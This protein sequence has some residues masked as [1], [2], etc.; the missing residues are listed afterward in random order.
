ML[1]DTASWTS[2]LLFSWLN[3]LFKMG[4]VRQLRSDDLPGLARKDHTVVWADRSVGAH[5]V[6]QAGRE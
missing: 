4:V 3:P 5:C 1:L 2:L 6:L